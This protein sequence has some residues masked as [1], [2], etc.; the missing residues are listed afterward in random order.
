MPHALMHLHLPVR[1]LRERDKQ[2]FFFGM[3]APARYGLG[4]KGCGTI[5]CEGDTYINYTTTQCVTPISHPQ[6]ACGSQQRVLVG[7]APRTVPNHKPNNVK[8]GEHAGWVGGWS[9]VSSC[10][11][12]EVL[13]CEEKRRD[14]PQYYMS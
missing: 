6:I 13:L 9:V 12:Q 1:Q 14:E 10:A 2:V 11:S 4:H 3:P 8:R 7:Q 5:P